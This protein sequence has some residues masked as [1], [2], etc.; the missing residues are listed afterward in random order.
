[1][2]R[3]DDAAE[4]GERASQRSRPVLYL[5]DAHDGA[6]MD[7]AQL[8]RPGEA[9]HVLPVLGDEVDVDAVAREPV[10][11]AVIGSLVDAPKSGVADIGEPGAELVSEQPEQSEHCVGVGGSVG[12]DLGWRE[13]GFLTEQQP[14]NDQAVA[15]RA[16]HDDGVQPGELV[17]DEVVVG[18][19]AAGAEVFWVRPGMDCA[20][21]CDKADAIGRGHLA[22][23]PDMG[24]RRGVL[25]GHDPGVGSRDGFGP[26]EVLA[27]PGQPRPAERR[28]VGPG[29]G[30]RSRCCRP[31]RPGR[32]TG[33]W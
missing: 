23:A 21:G 17:G 7:A 18:D 22:A 30:A 5:Q 13:V 12:H 24:D 2:Q 31:A 3:L 4:L 15:Q 8:Q 11:H 26:D 20:A 32:R 1:M 16:R 33:W 6:G 10:Q 27:D 25:R 14:Q 19:A 28:L 29:P 9:Q